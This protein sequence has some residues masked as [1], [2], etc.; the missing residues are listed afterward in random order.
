MK[1]TSIKKPPETIGFRL[2]AENSYSLALRANAMGVSVHD[3]ARTFLIQSLNEPDERREFTD[4]VKSLGRELGNIKADLGEVKT[5][6]NGVGIERS[7][8]R[9]NLKAL[10][11]EYAKLKTVCLDLKEVLTNQHQDLVFIGEALLVKAGKLSGPQ[12]KEWIVRNFHESLHH[13]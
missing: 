1:A 6:L 8:V 5:S 9:D 10:A 3:L 13:G 2:D 4:L 7:E 12:A 11:Q